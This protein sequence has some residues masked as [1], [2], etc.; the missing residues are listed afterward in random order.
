VRIGVVVFPG[1]NCDHDTYHVAKHVMGQEARFLWHKEESLG[2]VDAVILPGGF[3]YGDYLRTGAVARFSPIMRAV[4]E[5]A[6]RGG[7]VVGI[8]N[9]FQ[10][11]QEA[12]KATSTCPRTS[13]FAWRAKAR[14][15]SATS[16][17]TGG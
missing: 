9:G 7:P 16:R 10:I 15:S 6:A 5:F 11:L 1:S 14:S 4:T 12:G 2:G 8:C 3:A 13:W 17:R